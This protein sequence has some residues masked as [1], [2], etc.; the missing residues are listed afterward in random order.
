MGKPGFITKI[1]HS[2]HDDSHWLT[3]RKLVIFGA[4]L[5]I[6]GILFL[7]NSM[8]TIAYLMLEWFPAIGTIG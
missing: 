8:S 4:T 1:H 5:I 3:R 6:T 7:T 2:L